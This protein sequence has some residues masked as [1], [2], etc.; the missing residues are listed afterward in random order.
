MYVEGE[1]ETDF[2]KFTYAAGGDGESEICRVGPTRLE[3]RG[4][5]AV[6]VSL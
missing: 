2:K 5:I 6:W 1:V 3:T 4:K